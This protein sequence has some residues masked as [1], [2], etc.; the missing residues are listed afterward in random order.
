MQCG[1]KCAAPA[2][3]AM[4]NARWRESGTD[5]RYWRDASREAV[6]RMKRSAI[7]ELQPVARE[8]RVTLRFTRATMAALRRHRFFGQVFVVDLVLDRLEGRERLGRERDRL[9]AAV[10]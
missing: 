7:R 1:P 3:P 4:S 10:G 5:C 8:S 9:A 2:C 6:A